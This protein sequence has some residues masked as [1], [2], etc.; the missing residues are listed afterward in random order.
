MSLSQTNGRWI[1]S[2]KRSFDFVAARAL[3]D[4]MLE[5]VELCG[6]SRLCFDPNEA[7]QFKREATVKEGDIA[8]DDDTQTASND[9]GGKLRLMR[10]YFMGMNFLHSVL[11]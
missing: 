8:H 6:Y 9:W 4:L 7:R 10:L 1:A 3:A 11:E 2:K 5:C